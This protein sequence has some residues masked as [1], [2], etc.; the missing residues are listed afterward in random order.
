MLRKRSNSK[1]INIE[2]IE[3]KNN[4]NEY[5]SAPITITPPNNKKNTIFPNSTTI[6]EPETF[7]TEYNAYTGRKTRLQNSNAIFDPNNSSPSNEF[8]Q[9]LKLRMSVYYEQDVSIFS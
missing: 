7:Q 1:S 5:K 4:K 2:E 6:S 3:N 9:N 8:I